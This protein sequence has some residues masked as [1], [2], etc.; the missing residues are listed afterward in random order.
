MAWA[1]S[2]LGHGLLCLLTKHGIGSSVELSPKCKSCKLKA[3]E[4]KKTSLRKSRGVGDK[5]LPWLNKFGQWLLIT[6]PLVRPSRGILCPQEPRRTSHRLYLILA[7]LASPSAGTLLANVAGGAFGK[8]L[9][10]LIL[11][12]V[13]RFSSPICERA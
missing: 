13:L 2:F 7:S 11:L 3:K 10:M 8:G 12:S 4:P 6:L 1:V 5:V 9:E